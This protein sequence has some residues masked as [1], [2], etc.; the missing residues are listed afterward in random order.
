M[1]DPQ[2][3]FE[4]ANNEDIYS[5][6][7]K[8]S[9]DFVSRFQLYQA[10]QEWANSDDRVKALAIR[11]GGNSSHALDF[12]YDVSGMGDD[13]KK[14]KI[15]EKVFKPFFTEKLGS[16]YMKGWDFSYPTTLIK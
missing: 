15:L 3:A 8:F 12:R 14:G 5:G 11:G 6:C 13:V 16:D 10:A 1:K 7:V 4:D 9:S 2:K